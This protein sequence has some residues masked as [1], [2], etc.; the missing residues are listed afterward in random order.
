M[1]SN[2]SETT[3]PSEA[4]LNV[5]EDHRTLEPR[6]NQNVTLVKFI[7]KRLYINGFLYVKNHTSGNKV[8]WECLKYRRG[9]DNTKCPA[10]A[11]TSDPAISEKIILYR[12][13][14]ESE[15]NHEP[16]H[17]DIKYSEILVKKRELQEA[18]DRNCLNMDSDWISS[19][20]SPKL[21]LQET[22]L[23][24]QNEKL[25]LKE[26][27]MHAESELKRP[28]RST[29]SRTPYGFGFD[30][31]LGPSPPRLIGNKLY[32][33][34]YLYTRSTSADHLSRVHWRC[35]RYRS[36][37][38][39]ATAITSD[40]SIIQT[41]IVYKGPDESGHDHPPIQA[42]VEKA[43]ISAK[44]DPLRTHSKLNDSVE[45]SGQ[46]VDGIGQENARSQVG[47]T[48]RLATSDETETNDSLKSAR[49]D[50]DRGI[51]ASSDSND[52][53]VQ[54][55]MDAKLIGKRLY[56]NGYIYTKHANSPKVS[57]NC[58]RYRK[59][60]CAAKVFT[61]NV[62][63]GEELIIYSLDDLSTHNHLP[64]DVEVEEAELKAKLDFNRSKLASS[65]IKQIPNDSSYN[66]HHDPLQRS[67]YQKQEVAAAS[68]S[69]SYPTPCSTIKRELFKRRKYSKTKRN[70]LL[71]D[72]QVYR[73]FL[74]KFLEKPI[75]DRQSVIE[76]LQ[77]IY[78]S[79]QGCMVAYAT[80]LENRRK[81]ERDLK[82]LQNNSNF[83]VTALNSN[84]DS[85]TNTTPQDNSIGEENCGQNNPGSD[86]MSS[87]NC[88]NCTAI[89][90]GSIV[91]TTRETDNVVLGSCTTTKTDL[92][93]DSSVREPQNHSLSHPEK[94][95]GTIPP[96]PGALSIQ[97]LMSSKPSLPSSDQDDPIIKREIICIDLTDDSNEKLKVE[98]GILIREETAPHSNQTGKGLIAH[99]NS[100]PLVDSV[101]LR[102]ARNSEN[103][104]SNLLRGID[105]F[106]ALTQAHHQNEFAMP[107]NFGY[108]L[109][110]PMMYHP[111][112]Y[113]MEN[114]S[115]GIPD[116][117]KDV[118]K[119]VGPLPQISLRLLKN[120]TSRPK[121]L[122]L[123]GPAHTT[124]SRLMPDVFSPSSVLVN[125]KTTTG[126]ATTGY[127]PADCPIRN[128]LP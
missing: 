64:C 2:N 51:I 26:N 109:Y 125:S 86:G 35:C 58:K 81:I 48:S 112:N 9:N 12:G 107:P 78:S 97:D 128:Q 123:M 15:H 101:E 40:P 54:Y 77:V 66:I 82:N 6:F 67:Y 27:V 91:K 76:A 19:D 32:I 74:V 115:F 57:W 116:M 60:G 25:Q 22:T 10:G 65:Q 34:E 63:D 70:G 100:V 50:P 43:E 30:Y 106:G 8:Y 46:E 79:R 61:S 5:L 36:E 44:H 18:D 85:G 41:L 90:H 71:K 11:T 39:H 29:S 42:D 96:V 28:V 52:D 20:I 75:F 108:P 113:S 94:N 118:Q 119:F 103:Y 4:S 99:E 122:G 121:V 69:K 110:N 72:R 56:V 13:L 62:S 53:C 31:A 95:P 117:V 105:S 89:R 1:A 7:G 83:E 16:C 14:E 124:F 93:A 33:D 120:C 55:R 38:C 87:R 84:L 80:V 17:Q 21:E 98:P 37:K 23:L 68:D 111:F 104:L 102:S 49:S 92:L 59:T 88:S 73:K 126:R 114:P 3:P 127:V 45:S 24:R 47:C